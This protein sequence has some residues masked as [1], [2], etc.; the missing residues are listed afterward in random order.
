[1]VTNKILC[2]PS[3]EK[4]SDRKLVTKTRL[5]TSFSQSLYISDSD[6][7]N[8]SKIETNKRRQDAK[9]PATT[10]QQE[11]F[12]TDTTKKSKEINQSKTSSSS[13]SAYSVISISD[14][15]D[16]NDNNQNYNYYNDEQISNLQDNKSLNSTEMAK[17][18]DFFDNVPSLVSPRL[19]CLQARKE[20]EAEI[21]HVYVSETESESNDKENQ[22]VQQVCK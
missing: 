6:E 4:S 11:L 14:S 16:E 18:N 2:T 19:S 21:E 17:L 10:S 5:S 3:D 22:Q 12:S 1:M 13:K 7:T 8:C 20:Q 9:L 15:S